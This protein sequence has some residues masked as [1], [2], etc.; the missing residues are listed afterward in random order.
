MPPNKRSASVSIYANKLKCNVLPTNW[1]VIAHFHY[2]RDKMMAED[3]LLTIN[4]HP[5]TNLSLEL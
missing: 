5:S 3:V 1:D 4:S 2:I